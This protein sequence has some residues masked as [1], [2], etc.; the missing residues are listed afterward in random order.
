M[1]IDS[2]SEA[3]TAS[4]RE[5]STT[6]AHGLE[7]GAHRFYTFH[8][9]KKCTRSVTFALCTHRVQKRAYWIALM[10]YLRFKKKN[11]SIR[12]LI[13]EISSPKEPRSLQ[14]E[15]ISDMKVDIDGC[16]QIQNSIWSLPDGSNRSQTVRK[17]LQ[18]IFLGFSCCGDSHNSK[19]S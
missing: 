9:R 18:I 12:P 2:G 8:L 3:W 19:N 13:V 14:K 6:A 1:P 10:I 4:D 17:W 11:R 7:L 15:E 5:G 16:A